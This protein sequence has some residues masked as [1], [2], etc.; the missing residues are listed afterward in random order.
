LL[1]LLD[2][3]DRQRVRAGMRRRRFAAGQAIFHEGD[4]GDTLHLIEKGHVAVTV[5]TP[6]GDVVT[7]AVLGPG[8]TFGELALLASHRR[9]AASIVCLDAVETLSMGAEQYGALRASN[10]AIAAFVTEAL[11]EQVRAMTAR[12]VEALTVPAERRVLRRVAELGALYAEGDG[13]SVVRVTQDD[14]ATMAGTTRFTANRVLKAAE[15]DGLVSLRRGTIEIPDL[16]VLARRA[17]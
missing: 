1:D 16:H 10:P 11:T 3:H 8:Q 2:D 9:R 5:T 13:R 14:L 17:R 15:S 12:L 6:A 4:P 7:V